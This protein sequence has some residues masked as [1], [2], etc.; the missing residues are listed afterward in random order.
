MQRLVL[1]LSIVSQFFSPTMPAADGNARS[2]AP[3]ADVAAQQPTFAGPWR[4]AWDDPEGRGRL[5]MELRVNGRIVTGSVTLSRS[6]FRRTM[7]FNGE[8][9]GV[10]L[11]GIIQNGSGTV[12]TEIVI[13]RDGQSWVGRYSQ[14]GSRRNWPIDQGR[15]V[16]ARPN[17]PIPP[18]PGVGMPL[19]DTGGVAMALAPETASSDTVLV[20]DSRGC[21]FFNTRALDSGETVESS[22]PCINGRLHGEGRMLTKRNRVTAWVADAQRS[23]GSFYDAGKLNIDVQPSQWSL[24]YQC[25]EGDRAVVIARLPRELDF[26]QQAIYMSAIRIAHDSIRRRCPRLIYA[27]G[28]SGSYGTEDENASIFFVKNE[29]ALRTAREFVGNPRARIAEC[30]LVRNYFRCFENAELNPAVVVRDRRLRELAEHDQSVIR[31]ERRSAVLARYSASDVDLGLLQRN[32]FRYQGQVV[33]VITT[34]QTMRAANTA[35]FGQSPAEPEVYARAVP[36]RQFASPV[37][38]LLIGRVVGQT[39]QM[40]LGTNF[41]LPMLQYVGVYLCEQPRCPEITP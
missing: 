36:A 22:V 41:S 2:A 37:P 34:F 11:T 10:L 18:I 25:E 12:R 19:P 17:L 40:V 6:I 15:W 13:S 27:P 24:Q 38:V 7:E 5:E 4:G 31:G 8:L 21:S 1:M 30:Q 16:A 20:R 39:Q 33:A 29:S 9:H 28:R 23:G 35:L 32:P 14:E 26:G 3:D